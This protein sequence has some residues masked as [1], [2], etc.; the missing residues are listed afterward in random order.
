[1]INQPK[2]ASML[3]MAAA[4]L[5]ITGCANQATSPDT[6]SAK[7]HCTGVNECKGH[8]A[9]ATATNACA[10]QNACKG[11]GFVEMTESECKAKGGKIS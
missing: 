1:M 3:A 4:T 8:G 11:Q 7:V 10:G 2:T 6:T 5:L 9:C